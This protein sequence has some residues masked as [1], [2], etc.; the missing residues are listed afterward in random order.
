MLLAV[1]ATIL[2]A[3][4]MVKQ[5]RSGILPSAISFTWSQVMEATFFLL[6]SPEA[7]WIFA[8][9]LMEIATGGCLTSKEKDLSEYTVMTTGR[10]LPA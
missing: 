7:V 9:S 4:A 1:P 2:I 10:T 3:E 5:L 6:G 8:A